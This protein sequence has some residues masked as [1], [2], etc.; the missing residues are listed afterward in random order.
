MKYSAEKK[1]A[2]NCYFINSIIL[3]V[4]NVGQMQPTAIASGQVFMY[5]QYLVCFLMWF[6]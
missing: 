3:L 2:L 6:V 5:F 4:K 1:N